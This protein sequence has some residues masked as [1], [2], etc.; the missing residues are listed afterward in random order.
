MKI[1]AY[2][3]P[4]GGDVLGYAIAED[5]TGLTSH[6]SSNPTWS[7]HD[8]GVTSDWHHDGYRKHY[9]DGYEVVWVEDI[10]THEGLRTALERNSAV[11]EAAS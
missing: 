10:E 2:C 7:Q 11:A 9:P 5:G 8:L 4:W 6:L 3:T 1:Y